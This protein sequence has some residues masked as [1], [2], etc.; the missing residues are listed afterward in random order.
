MTRFANVSNYINAGQL[1]SAGVLSAL[2]AAQQTSPNFAQTAQIAVAEQAKNEIQRM[3]LESKHNANAYAN[4]AAAAENTYYATKQAQKTQQAADYKKQRQMAG[5]LALAS[6][7]AKL[8]RERPDPIIPNLK[9]IPQDNSATLQAIYDKYASGLEDRRSNVLS[10]ADSLRSSGQQKLDSIVTLQPVKPLTPEQLSSTTKSLT[11]FIQ[12]DPD[13]ISKLITSEAER[14]TDD[15]LAVL[16]NVYLR[17][18]SPDFPST[19]SAVAYQKDPIQYTGMYTENAKYDPELIKRLLQPDT[20]NRAADIIS[21]LEQRSPK[22][23]YRSSTAESTAGNRKPTD[24]MF[25]PA[26]NYYF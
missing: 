7:L 25:S 14:G 11:E 16:G 12:S 26:G 3:Q 23:Q 13:T 1:A 19:A 4:K 6:Q 5:R 15:E 20:L 10:D 8:N 24:L 17:A 18:R 9:A 22:L 21:Q 2:A